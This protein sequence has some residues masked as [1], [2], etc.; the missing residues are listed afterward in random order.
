MS[1]RIKF[2]M[3]RYLSSFIISA[4]SYTFVGASLFYFFIIKKDDKSEKCKI[5]N[6][7]KISFTVVSQPEEV[8]EKIEKIEKPEEPKPLPKPIEKAPLPK[9]IEKKEPPKPIVQKEPVTEPVKDEPI[10]EP[11]I[12]SEP[13]VQKQIK[14]KVT[15]EIEKVVE[16]DTKERDREIFI[17]NLIKRINDN[18]SYPQAARR[19]SIQDSVEVEFTILIDGNVN[20]IKVLSGHDIFEK[21]AMQAIENSFPIEVDKTLFDFPKKF[22]VKIVYILK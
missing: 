1:M 19:R 2:N 4:I 12:K 15:P 3:N 21:S 10:L 9:P 17:Q 7:Q 14:E 18:K 13:Q 20:S 6:I 22:K 5:E 11:T 16:N 8:E